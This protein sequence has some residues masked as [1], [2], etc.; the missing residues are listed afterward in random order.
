MAP[1]ATKP[2]AAPVEKPAPRAKTAEE[3]SATA[4][5][6]R[7]KAAGGGSR[8]R[9]ELLGIAAELF[10]ARGYTETTVRDIADEAGILSGSLY[11]HFSSKETMLDEILR[12]FLEE[13]LRRFTEIEAEESDP[14]RVFDRMVAV[15]FEA[16]E[17]QPRA[18]ALYQNESA[19]IGRLPGFAYVDEIGGKI[20]ALWLRVLVAGQ[21]SGAFRRDLDMELTYRFIRDTVWASVRWYR[22]GG[23]YRADAVAE[24]FLRLMRTGL[25]A[26]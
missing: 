12:G 9:A 3:P 7:G 21:K 8:R 13:L 22:P 5:R 4:P 15:S 19:S 11:H 17:T 25:S 26:D 10:N 6:N 18:V 20:E 1:R 2:K 23:K 14:K 16:I 24:Q